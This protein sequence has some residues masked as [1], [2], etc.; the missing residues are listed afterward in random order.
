[1]NKTAKQSTEEIFSYDALPYE[2]ACCKHSHPDALYN[3]AQSNDFSA[4][5]YDTARILELGCGLGGNLIPYALAFPGA[6]CIGIDLSEQQIDEAQELAAAL[7][8]DNIDFQCDDITNINKDFGSFD[9][10]LC[11]GVF[12]WVPQDVRLKILELC[13]DLLTP[14]GLAVISYNALPGWHFDNALRDAMRF[15]TRACTTGDK[16]APARE[17]YDFLAA[18]SYEDTPFRKAY[19]AFLQDEA[20][21]L[22]GLSDTY[23]YHDQ[24]AAENAAFYLK[25]FADM[26]QKHGLD[27]VGDAVQGK[28]ALDKE[29]QG[30]LKTID[31]VVDREQYYDFLTN[32]R[33]HLSIVTPEGNKATRSVKTVDVPP[34]VPVNVSEKPKSWPLAQ[35]QILR[36]R[37]TPMVTTI[38]RESIKTTLLLNL[39]T[40]YAD[41][42]RTA[43]DLAAKMADHV[44]N[45]DIS[46]KTAKGQPIKADLLHETLKS[47]IE[48]NLKIMAEAGLL[49]T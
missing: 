34:P 39:L 45:G 20:K 8:I 25:D 11:H 22:S 36:N 47:V 40:L 17:F 21:V 18:H 10:I 32:R 23:L 6:A 38:H 49:V 24:L 13:R 35:Q 12:S 26:A 41:G 7:K 19:K 29:A 31:N 28:V 43:D 48:S 9:Y 46:L 5:K 1:M 27:Y 30:F 3:V 42:T 2:S 16:I 4:V 44:K 33:F 14:N 37:E 15:H